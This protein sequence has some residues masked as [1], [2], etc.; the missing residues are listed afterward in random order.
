MQH[1]QS[2]KKFLKF[3][4]VA[5]ALLL[6]CTVTAADY[7]GLFRLKSH[8]NRYATENATTHAMSTASSVTKK[9][10]KQMW[11][12]ESSGSAY[13]IRNAY[14]GR[15]IPNE[16]GSDAA[17]I[18]VESPISLYIKESAGD[19][20]WLSISWESSYSG[21]SCLH[22]NA[23]HNV[24]KWYANNAD[25]ENPNSDWQLEA[26][27][28]I[29]TATIRQH[30]GE[31]TG[32]T[33]TITDGY[34]RFVPIA[35]SGYSLAENTDKSTAV[36]KETRDDD[37]TQY[38]K[39]TVKNDS[40]KIQNVISGYYLRNNMP[41]NL[42]LRTSE[43]DQNNLFL[44]S[45]STLSLWEPAFTF[46][47]KFSGFAVKTTNS[48][49]VGGQATSI[50]S[51]WKLLKVELDS[52]TIAQKR[53]EG[54]DVTDIT[55]NATTYNTKLQTFFKDY[56]CTI[57]RD[58]YASMSEADLRAAMA[59]E[60][61]PL[62]LQDM[63]VC[64]LTDQW[65]DDA[66]RSKYTKLFRIQDVQIYSNNTAW[67]SITKVGPWAELINPT[68]IQGRSGDVVFIFADDVPLDNDATLKAQLAY[69][70]QYSNK[71]TLTLKKGLNIWTLPEDGEVFIGYTLNNTDRK[72][73]EY[74]D[75]RIHIERGTV[76]GYWD[77]SR[78]MTN[79]DWKWLKA[80]MFEGEFLH[81]K[82]KSTVLNVLR[83]KVIG[84]T[85]VVNIMKGWDYSFEKLEYLI[86][87]DGQWDDRYRPVAN[88]RHSYKDNPN[89]A[90]YAGSNHP[91]I[92][93]SYLF[94]YDNF[95]EGNVWEIL[96]ELGHGH[97]YPINMAG[98]TEITNNSLSQMVSYMFGRCYSRGD[99]TEKLM[100]LFNYEADGHRGWTWTD[101]TRS[102]KPFYDASLHVGNHLLYQLYL[103]FEVL[104]NCPNFMPRLCDELRSNPIVTG[105]SVSNPT[106]YYNDY[107][108]VAKA[109]AKVSKTNLWE[110]FEAYG[111]WKY[112]DDVISARDDDDSEEAKS[113]GIRFI[114]DY[115]NYYMKVP[116]R[117]NEDDE[118]RIKELK[119]YMQSM[120]RKAHNIFFIDDRI[121]TSYVKSNSFVAS[122]DRKLVGK[123]LLDYW[124]L[125]S[126]GDFGHYTNFDGKDRS[127]NLGYTIGTEQDSVA[128]ETSSGGDTNYTVYGR[129]VTMQGSGILG[130]KIYNSDGEL[131]HIANTRSFVL[132]NEIADGL[133]DGTY[134]LFVAVRAGEDIEMGSNGQPAGIE[135]VESE[136]EK[137]ANAPVRDLQ[138][139][140]VTQ[141]IP[142]N[143]YIKGKTKFIAH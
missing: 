20:E 111:F 143:I 34:Y 55:K 126:Q 46:K 10:L 118:N 71:G 60:G 142:G 38:W 30:I 61:L 78:G 13:T 113:K 138:G 22:D 130:I 80:N 21:T 59:A 56:A 75:I 40:I 83:D 5:M 69:D 7:T 44:P 39:V 43:T 17:L 106:Y 103:Y 8:Y 81:V 136:A 99:G 116:V 63:A 115:G 124:S 65:D 131:C 79:A 92:S 96:H 18:T 11:I 2:M 48:T 82:G 49:V 66:T 109:C 108:R 70:T 77:L 129:K 42:Q 9:D 98:T 110:F 122:I 6:A 72:L 4:F 101:Y 90:S 88:P 31:V 23:G 52:A 68:G 50:N 107:F 26:V 62:T 137:D 74:P 16:G 84:A 114:G 112:Y 24:V 25:K 3:S 95:Y 93:S 41:T 1:K 29:D 67:K 94:N 12:I 125:P 87:N 133:E 85:D 104:G 54:S 15:Y 97:Q 120:P 128:M 105:N 86:G 100:Q 127:A 33:T 139:R 132:P 37:Y 58:E 51:S 47:G 45:E 14:S 35:A 36:V 76:N 135:A 140:I 102:A 89:W 91:D 119:E 64:V 27:T 32:I 73:S 121:N 53:S 19:S 134:K 141:T 123:K 57:L 117:G 28:D